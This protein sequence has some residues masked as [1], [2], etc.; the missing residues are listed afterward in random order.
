MKTKIKKEVP[1]K[2]K[3]KEMMKGFKIDQM[4]KDMNDDWL[5]K[6]RNFDKNDN[7]IWEYENC[8]DYLS[9]GWSDKDIKWEVIDS[10]VKIFELKKLIK[11]SG[12]CQETN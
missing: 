2:N 10:W 4:K 1:I 8:W 5:I 6:S 3:L 9:D 11:E 7:E 12:I